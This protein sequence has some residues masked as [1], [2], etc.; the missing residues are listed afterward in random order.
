MTYFFRRK[1]YIAGQIAKLDL[2]QARHIFG[3][4]QEFLYDKGYEPFNP[5]DVDPDSHCDRS[6]VQAAMAKMETPESLH[7]RHCYIKQDL[8]VMLE[9]DGVALL[10]NWTHSQGAINEIQVA[11]ICGLEIRPLQGWLS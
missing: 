7:A 4:A 11:Y 3:R 2:Q 9:C 10:Y 5:F 1:I 8:K 6:C